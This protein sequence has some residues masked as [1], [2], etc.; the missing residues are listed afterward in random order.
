[1]RARGYILVE[2]LVALAVLTLVLGAVL[3]TVGQS[4][5]RNRAALETRRALIVARSELAAVGNDIPAQPGTRTGKSDAMA[6]RVVIDPAAAPGPLGQL[7]RITVAV[8]P[9]AAHPRVTLTEL[10]LFAPSSTDR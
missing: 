3:V 10:R 9:D 5:A 8:G 6:W 4:A 1:M 2:S 7:A